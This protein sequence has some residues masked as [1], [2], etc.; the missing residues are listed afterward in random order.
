MRLGAIIIDDDP[1][2]RR[3]VE[4]LLETMHCQVVATGDDG[5][6]AAALYEA[7]GPDLVLL[8]INMPRV[9]GLQ[10]L[11]SLLD[12]HPDAHVVMLTGLA[13]TTMAESCMANGAKDFLRKDAGPA[14][15]RGNLE[16]VLGEVRATAERRGADA[17]AGRTAA[18][19]AGESGGDGVLDVLARR[20]SVRAFTDQP[21][22]DEL[23]RKVLAA[24]QHA[25]TSSNLQAYS[26]VVVRAPAT[27]AKLAELAGGQDHVAKCPVFVAVCADIHRLDAVL[28]QGGGELAKGHLEMSMVAVIDAAL[29]GMSASLAA[30][31][32]GLGGCMIGGMRNDPVGVAEVLGL[33]DGVFVVFGMT[34][35]FPADRPPSK[36]RYP[37][38]GVVHWERYEEKP[39]GD[40]TEAYNAALEAQKEATGRTDGVVWSERLAKGFSK[41]KRP[42]LRQALA[43]LGFDFE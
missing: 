39:L 9:N 43:E 13:D 38:E 20:A 35:G 40:L 2:I 25:P 37:A 8:D 18:L 11:R 21:V 27:K 12:A 42:G 7:H 41:P 22:T 26:F 23:V 29:C 33:P 1:L 24:A 34:L 30:D 36:P 19:L 5:A 15:L 3:L 32:L 14:D 6:N 10:A 4:S 17:T 16:R 28:E 31:S